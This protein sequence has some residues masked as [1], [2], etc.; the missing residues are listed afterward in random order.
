MKAEILSTGDEIRSGA[1][2]DSNSAFIA[3]LLEQ[4]GVDV[5]RHTSVGDDLEVLA[6]TLREIG[7]R[8]DVGVVTGGLGPTTDDLS[9]E[10]AA[11]AAGVDLAFNAQVFENVES[12]FK[13]LKH[14]MSESNR[15]QALLPKGCKVLY[16][17]D[18]FSSG[19]RSGC[20]KIGG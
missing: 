2:V 17:S 6:A 8:V 13:I 20:Q 1:L 11:L 14:P 12:F 9:A 7:N 3:D 5:I 10:A 16:N 19:P 18:D 4:N 15:K